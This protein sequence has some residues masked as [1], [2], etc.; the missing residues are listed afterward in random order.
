VVRDNIARFG[1]DPRNVTI[2]GESAGGLDINVLMTPLAKGLYAIDRGERPG[3]GPP[4]FAEGEKRP[5]RGG[6]L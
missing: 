3:G 2:F 6:H 4:S 5:R 1:G